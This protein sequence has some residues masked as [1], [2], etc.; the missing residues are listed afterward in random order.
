MRFYIYESWQRVEN[1]PAFEVT[2]T[3]RGD[4][5]TDTA[6]AFFDCDSISLAAAYALPAINDAGINTK[7]SVIFMAE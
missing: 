5:K 6:V 1:Q 2:S 4:D 3:R 7:N